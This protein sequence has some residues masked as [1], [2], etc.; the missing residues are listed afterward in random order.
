MELRNPVIV[1]Q[2]A[3]GGSLQ[4]LL[5]GDALSMA[6]KLRAAHDIATGMM[7]LYACDPPIS[8]RD[9][10]SANVLLNA[11]GDCMIAD[12]GCVSIWEHRLPPPEGP[13]FG[14]ANFGV[15]EGPKSHL[16]VKASCALR[17]A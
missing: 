8:H 14:K 9:L 13:G 6:D 2:L 3:E 11:E 10:K 7:H 4:T 12:F 1:M 5:A 17:G 16:P 15:R